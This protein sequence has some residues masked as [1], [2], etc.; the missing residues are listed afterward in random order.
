MKTVFSSLALIAIVAAAPG[1]AAFANQAKPAGGWTV[2]YSETQCTAERNFAQAGRDLALSLT[3]ALDGATYEVVISE[4]N[5]EPQLPQQIAA[6]ATF[7][8]T[9]VKTLALNYRD[10][11]KDRRTYRVRVPASALSQG[12]GGDMAFHAGSFRASLESTNLSGALAALET[13]MKDLRAYWNVAAK[14]SLQPPVAKDNL[15]SLLKPANH[16]GADMW[17]GVKGS[18]RYVLFID[19]SGNLAGCEAVSEDASPVLALLGCDILRAKGQF[20]PARDETGAP[21]RSVLT[22]EDVRW[23]IG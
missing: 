3:P 11:N 23:R 21:V 19:A 14:Q 9:A 2:N 8:G 15:A 4:G 16:D 1:Q 6:K 10:P 18:A 17:G 20:T 22:T 5:A 13:C 7:G 12:S